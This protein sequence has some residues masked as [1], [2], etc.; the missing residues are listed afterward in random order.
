M[1]SIASV[2]HLPPVSN[3]TTT[4]RQRSDSR[5]SAYFLSLSARARVRTTPF[6]E[7]AW[8]CAFPPHV[9]A[10][11]RVTSTANC[12]PWCAGN[13]ETNTSMDLS[14]LAET[15]TFISRRR[16]LNRTVAPASLQMRAIV[17]SGEPALVLNL[18][19][20]GHAA[21]C[22]PRVSRGVPHSHCDSTT[23][24][25]NRRR[26]R[27]RVRKSSGHT[28]NSGPAGAPDNTLLE[29]GPAWDRK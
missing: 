5:S 4:N 2:L 21:L 16:V 18:P 11:L 15:A 20:L 7:A 22:L 8:G 26:S 1:N 14:S 19:D 3:A 24:N 28:L 27:T 10:H 25:G 9:R 17:L 6:V 12:A 29:P 23:S 13:P